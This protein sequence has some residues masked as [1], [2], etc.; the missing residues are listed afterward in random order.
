M[1]KCTIMSIGDL[2][3]A[4]HQNIKAR[5]QILA[6]LTE[7]N[8]SIPVALH[9]SVSQQTLLI[10]WKELHLS[11]RNPQINMTG[12]IR[13]LLYVSN[14]KTTY[15]TDLLQ[16]KVED[17]A[18]NSVI[19]TAAESVPIAS[20]TEYIYILE[21]FSYTHEE[22]PSFLSISPSETPLEDP[23]S[24][25]YSEPSDSSSTDTSTS[26]PGIPS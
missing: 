14:S 24:V 19:S 8:G 2:L 13:S 9:S 22:P 23:T 12:P 11:V 1:G 17:R 5:Y 6:T 16:F 26:P 20:G 18:D 21:T 15:I 4:Y 10:L 3:R 25:S 7:T